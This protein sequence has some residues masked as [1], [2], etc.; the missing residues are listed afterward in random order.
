MANILI[1]PYGVC[2]F[3]GTP[4]NVETGAMT[5]I[6]AD[7]KVLLRSFTV[8]ALFCV[9]THLSLAFLWKSPA[10]APTLAYSIG[11]Y[12]VISALFVCGAKR[13]WSPSTIIMVLLSALGLMSLVSFSVKL[14]Y[15]DA[16]ALIQF[17]QNQQV[18]ARWLGG[19]WI[20]GSIF[21]WMNGL[22]SAEEVIRYGGILSMLLWTGLA[23][24]MQRS[25]T[26][27]LPVV[28]TPLFLLFFTGYTEYYPF[29]AGFAL[30][31]LTWIF[32]KDLREHS[33]IGLALITALL[34]WLYLGFVP[35]SG[36]LIIIL[37]FFHPLKGVKT[38]ILS[39]GIFLLLVAISWPGTIVE[40]FSTITTELI[41]G[42]FALVKR[43]RAL[44]QSDGS[45]YFPLATVFH[46]RH[47]IDLLS[48]LCMGAGLALPIMGISTLITSTK[49]LKEVRPIPLRDTRV[50]F[51]AALG[52]FYLHYLFF[53]IPRLGPRQDIDLF[54]LPYL[55]L[56]YL[57]G[58][59]LTFH[60]PK[61]PQKLD[62]SFIFLG[63][64]LPPFI[65]LLNGMPP[66][67][68]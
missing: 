2:K 65:L 51:G 52:A 34:P 43:Y 45:I 60:A 7:T 57:T 15:G 27:I 33:T 18:F 29:I 62:I 10:F 1:S 58:E 56:G 49:F 42:E 36:M 23:V 53:M 17:V 55:I 28:F 46:P 39:A 11:V 25:S 19:T 13:Q 31:G 26:T 24:G 8:G 4:T 48:M 47:I 32:S 9:L 16:R 6:L 50:I 14:D 20:Y 22:T 12:L 5:N 68:F 44:V 63:G 54:F 67:R 41:P 40:Y 3:Y 37:L 66:L 30:F 35:A 61:H 64:T 59:L 21:S 38:A